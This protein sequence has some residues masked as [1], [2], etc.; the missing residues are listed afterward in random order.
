MVAVI[1]RANVLVLFVLFSL[2]ASGCASQSSKPERKDNAL[3]K[4]CHDP[5]PQICTREYRPVCGTRDTG[6]RCVTTPCASHEYK[7]Y[8]NACT[9]CADPKVIEYR[10]GACTSI[11]PASK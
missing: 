2:L 9:A 11:N 1:M 6:V 5:R 4:A 10:H 8:G 7:T 3:Y